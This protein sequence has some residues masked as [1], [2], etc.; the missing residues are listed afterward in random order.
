MAGESI[1]QRLADGRDAVR[2]VRI[3]GLLLLAGSVFSVPSALALDPQPPVAE[4][5]VSA[6]GFGVSFVLLFAPGDRIN[7]SWI[8][9]CLAIGIVLT[10]LA[11]GLMSDDYAFFYVVIAIYAAFALRTRLE[12]VVFSVVIGAALFAPLVYSDEVRVQV[13]HILVTVPVLVISLIFVR[14]LRETLEARER[15]Y[16]GFAKEAVDIAQRIRDRSRA[17][18]EGIAE[19]QRRLDELAE[20]T[21]VKRPEETS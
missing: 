11:V 10:A 17:S 13:H 4:F 3:A 20:R 15:T 2:L 19:E 18:M 1:M 7:G 16:L 5:L 6:T 21:R 9:F 8:P 12:L 14:Y